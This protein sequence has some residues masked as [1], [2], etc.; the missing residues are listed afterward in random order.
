MTTERVPGHTLVSEGAAFMCGAALCH[1]RRG[2]SYY[3]DHG[4]CLLHGLPL[5]DLTPLPIAFAPNWDQE[6]GG[7]SE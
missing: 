5:A 2:Q 1:G 4:R 6:L 7:E 3:A